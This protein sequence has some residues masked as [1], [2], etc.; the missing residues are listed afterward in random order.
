M[1]KRINRAKRRSVSARA[2]ASSRAHWTR[3]RR[4]K[5]QLGQHALEGKKLGEYCEEAEGRAEAEEQCS[6]IEEAEEEEDEEAEA[7]G[8]GG[9]TFRGL[10]AR[11]YAL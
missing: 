8:I 6:S 11:S 2:S 10:K 3:S 7:D 5:S 9:D 4:S 1:P